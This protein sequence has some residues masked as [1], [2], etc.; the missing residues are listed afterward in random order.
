[1]SNEE[2]YHLVVGQID[3][4]I[5]E[6]RL[7]D[8]EGNLYRDAKYVIDMSDDDFI[9]AKA[10]GYFCEDWDLKI[11]AIELIKMYMEVY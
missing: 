2:E 9:R 5:Y 8:D 6:A 4:D 7:E 11:E 10:Y 1:M 3:T